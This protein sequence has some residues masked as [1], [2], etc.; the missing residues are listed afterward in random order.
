MI[1]V[2]YFRNGNDHELSINGHAGYAE[3]GQDIVCAGV[4]A[5]AF[6]LLG[7][8]EECEDEVEELDGPIVECGSIYISCTGNQNI[9]TAFHMAVCGLKQ[10]ADSYADYVD[11]QIL[12]QGE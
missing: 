7:Y 3:H 6:A 11:I 1:R 4:S 2:A 8:L 5:I 9:A 10:I 12:P